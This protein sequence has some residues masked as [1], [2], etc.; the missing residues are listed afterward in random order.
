MAD[1]SYDPA[2]EKELL[3]AAIGTVHRHW[4]TPEMGY[5]Y[6]DLRQAVTHAEHVQAVRTDH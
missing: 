2:Q 1:L 6:E 4:G 3:S 5:A